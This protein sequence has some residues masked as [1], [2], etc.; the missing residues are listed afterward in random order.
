[1][2]DLNLVLALYP[3][4]DEMRAFETWLT[5]TIPGLDMGL[6]SAEFKALKVL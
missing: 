3:D 5:T 1:M 4:N 2:K 6:L